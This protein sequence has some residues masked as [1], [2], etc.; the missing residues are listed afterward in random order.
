MVVIKG[1][2]CG[3]HQSPFQI[4][5]KNADCYCH[6]YCADERIGVEPACLIEEST[7]RQRAAKRRMSITLTLRRVN[8]DFSLPIA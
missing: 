2:L 4:S 1:T 6:R 5:S 3:T 8:Q 7:L